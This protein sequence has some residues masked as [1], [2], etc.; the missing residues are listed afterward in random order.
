MR[1]MTGTVLDETKSQDPPEPEVMEIAFFS[2]AKRLPEKPF[3]DW[4]DEGFDGNRR[5]ANRNGKA[6][7]LT[8]GMAVNLL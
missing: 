2:P 3:L 1:Y 7:C 4:S 6:S 8:R 5:F